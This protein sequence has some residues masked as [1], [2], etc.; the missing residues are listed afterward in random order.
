MPLTL[1]MSLPRLAGMLKPADLT[2]HFYTKIPI[3]RDLGIQVIETSA[4]HAKVLVSLA[5]NLNHVQTAFGGSL[6]AAAALSCYA[7]FQSIAYG[8]GGFSDELVIQEGRIQYL[9]PV[10]KDFEVESRLDSANESKV[11]VETLR[12]H[13]KARLLLKAV[14]R[15]QGSSLVAARFEGTYVYRGP[16]TGVASIEERSKR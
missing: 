7:L 12:R 1:Q 5:P 14:V 10:A 4:L 11:F 15:E 3:S 6:Y 9:A 13:G 16:K 8:A 2:Q